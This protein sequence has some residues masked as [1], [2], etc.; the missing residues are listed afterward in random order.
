MDALG[1]R[2]PK[3]DIEVRC[4][5]SLK[6]TS[7]APIVQSA[8]GRCTPK[9]AAAL[10]DRSMPFDVRF[11]IGNGKKMPGDFPVVATP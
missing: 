8:R 5:H 11:D 7:A 1:Q 4:L 6:R 3:C 10:M 9:K 2:N